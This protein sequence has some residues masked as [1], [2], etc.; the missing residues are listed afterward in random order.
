[1]I[2]TRSTLVAAVLALAVGLTAS[3][4]SAGAPTPPASAPAATK[5]G[6]VSGKVVGKDGKPAVGANVRFAAVTP[7][8]AT[9]TAPGGRG[10]RGARGP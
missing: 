8:S 6:S 7:G 1:M 5:V 2:S 4:L 3:L 9:A 10:A